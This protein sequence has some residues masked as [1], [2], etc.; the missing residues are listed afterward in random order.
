MKRS[1][2]SVAVALVVGGTCASQS[3]CVI[4]EALNAASHLGSGTFER[5]EK[6]RTLERVARDW[7][8]TIRA[9]QVV[10]VYPLDE[11]IEVGD[12]YIVDTPIEE[13]KG[14]WDSRG[15]LPI[16]HRFAR[17]Q[18]SGFAGYYH[19]GGYGLSSLAGVPRLWQFPPADTRPKGPGSAGASADADTST[20][21]KPA[22]MDSW[23]QAPRAGFPVYSFRI[24]RGEGINTAIPVEGIPVAL[25]ALGAREATG[26]VTLKNA[27]TYGIDEVSLRTDLSCWAS[28][29]EIR[30][31]LKAYAPVASGR[32]RGKRGR[33]RSFL[34]VV[35][36]VY[37]IRGITVEVTNASAS[38]FKGS[39]GAPKG[40]DKNI[41]F[42]TSDKPEDLLLA[43]LQEQ[44][45]G[46]QLA[47]ALGK[48][49][50]DTTNAD[51]T[52]NDGEPAQE[53]ASQAESGAADADPELAERE[54]ELARQEKEFD[55]EERA[56]EL[57][58]RRAN[59]EA[60][61]KIVER[62]LLRQ[63]MTDRFGGYQLPGATLQVASA[64]ANSISM[65]ETFD[66]PLVIGYHALEFEILEGGLLRN[67]P[68]STFQ[69][70][71]SNVEPSGG[72]LVYGP[73]DE[74]LTDDLVRWWEESHA[75]RAQAEQWL[76]HHGIRDNWATFILAGNEKI[77]D[78]QRKLAR[79]VGLR[80]SCN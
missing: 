48:A 44:I 15:Y 73:Q 60:T 27:Y 12:S 78:L 69:R 74:R 65:N 24:K 28:R 4:G 79:D 54:K 76:E 43:K 67:Q 62:S 8:L 47:T 26:S 16:D 72:V 46:Q 25:A 21:E 11:D 30:E 38:A 39:V 23:E 13:L 35:T 56:A 33:S 37:L 68:V 51:T 6:Q 41:S 66:R 20:P 22:R 7:C 40:A 80:P 17:F 34:R 3:G 10:P 14:Y 1:L 49:S 57:A 5:I 18:P 31:A 71:E 70:L 42:S 75:H 36:R 77:Y 53:G 19:H 63:E 9:S 61:D 50:E 58:Q 52:S 45:A 55:L 32:Q 59:R 2:I 29:S 64:T